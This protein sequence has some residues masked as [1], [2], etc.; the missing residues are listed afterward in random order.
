[1]KFLTKE[2]S[3]QMSKKGFLLSSPQVNPQ[4]AAF[5]EPFYQE[6]YQEAQK[7][8]LDLM[9]KVAALSRKPFQAEREA[10]Q[11]RQTHQRRVEELR[12]FLP[13]EILDQVADVRVLALDVSTQE[14]KGAAARWCR[15]NRQQAEQVFQACL[16]WRKQV[17]PQVGAQLQDRFSFHDSTVTKVERAPDRLTLFLEDGGYS[18]V[19]RVDFLSPHILEEDG[20]WRAPSGSMRRSTPPKAETSTTPCCG[21]KMT[22]CSISRYLQKIFAC[23]RSNRDLAPEAAEKDIPCPQCA[24]R[25]CPLFVY[26]MPVFPGPFP[27]CPWGPP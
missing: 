19:S 22:S 26:V 10:E 2:W 25:G 8:H 18:P 15:E 16:D 7:K 17:R 3:Q 23:M 27:G 5:S 12:R 24:G 21:G 9:R 11:F 14:V 6:L 4:A 1:M 20:G 13:Q